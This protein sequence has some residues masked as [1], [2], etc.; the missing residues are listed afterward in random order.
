VDRFPPEGRTAPPPDSADPGASD[1]VVVL[2]A[3]TGAVV[4]QRPVERST[5]LAALDGDVVTAHGDTDGFVHVTRTDPSGSA[6]R[7]DFVSPRPLAVRH[8]G[9]GTRVEVVDGLVVVDE[10]DGWVLDGDGHVLRS[11]AGTP[12]A[13]LDGTAHVVGGRLLTR[14]H[15][16]GGPYPQ[17]QV[18][19]LVTG[20]TFT[21]RGRPLDP[22]PDDGSLDG[23][24]LARA[25]GENGLASYDPSTGRQR[26]SAPGAVEGRALV[27]G[28]RVVRV[29][30]RE[31]TAVDGRTGRP[32]WQASLVRPARSSLVSDGRLVVVTQL[33]G[34]RGLVLGAYGLD[35]GRLRWSVDVADDVAVLTV[36]GGQLFGW[37]G[38]QLVALT[39]PG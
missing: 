39:P 10:S 32:V 5:T 9:W 30:S 36:L 21:V 27:L 2:D 12:S 28:G 8:P 14:P 16:T 6:V 35:D 3:R 7:W 20:Q 17:T 31:M 13:Q 34:D 37:T 24:M 25:G 19:D 33:D 11:W 26:W 4:S 29:T 15:T 18:T 23:S 22:W 38:E 1:R